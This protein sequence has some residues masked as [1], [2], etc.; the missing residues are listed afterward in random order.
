MQTVKITIETQVTTEQLNAILAGN[1][2]ETLGHTIDEE[3]VKEAS[4]KTRA[5]KTKPAVEPETVEAAEES[6]EIDMSEFKETATNEFETEEKAETPSTTYADANAQIKKFY[7]KHGADT[8]T[9]VLK[10]MGFASLEQLKTKGKTADF[11]KAMK[12]FRVK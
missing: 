6:S 2:A 5:R 4:T 9:Q 7:A 12:A 1:T 3:N 10:R 11:E 8:T